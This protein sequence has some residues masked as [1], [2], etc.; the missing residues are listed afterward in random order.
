MGSGSGPIGFRGRVDARFTSDDATAA[1]AEHGLRRP[2]AGPRRRADRARVGRTDRRLRR[3]PA[4][5]RDRE[6]QADSLRRRLLRPRRRPDVARRS[7]PRVAHA[8]KR[9]RVDG[10]ATRL[11]PGGLVAARAAQA[12]R[13]RARAVRDPRVRASRRGG[14]SAAVTGET[15]RRIAAACS[16]WKSGRASKSG[17]ANSRAAVLPTRHTTGTLSR[18][19]RSR[20][21]ASRHDRWEH[22]FGSDPRTSLR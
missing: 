1:R 16:E 4:V 6:G 7:D 17:R 15:R 13:R 9:R 21:F 18:H 22:D 5:L 10:A 11:T 14:T 12:S 8:A 19:T 2:L 3:P 20:F